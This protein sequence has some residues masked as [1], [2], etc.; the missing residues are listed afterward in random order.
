M[1]VLNNIR[2]KVYVA[3]VAALC[4]AAAPAG[5]AEHTLSREY[6][7]KAAFLYNF[8]KF[9]EWPEEAYTDE[10]SPGTICVLGADPFGE[11]FDVIE[12]KTA[13]GR[14]I[15]VRRIRGV[16]GAG[17]CHILFIGSS[18]ASRLKEVFRAAEGEGVLTVGETK[19]FARSG[20]AVNFFIKK[21]K[22][23]F[24]INVDAVEKAGLKMSSKLLNL[25]VI[26]REDDR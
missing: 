26:V 6:E 4:L 18:E 19:D 15:R 21:D 25:A 2:G 20:G 12:G 11:A 17:E 16:A 9:V 1:A 7:I 14:S 23:R 22:V 10:N 5:Y 3:V 8:L 24:E 13:R